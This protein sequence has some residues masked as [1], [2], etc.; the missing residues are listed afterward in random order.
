MSCLYIYTRTLYLF[1]ILELF[2]IMLH[3]HCLEIILWCKVKL[4]CGV[5]LFHLVEIS[6]K[7]KHFWLEKTTGFWM[8][9]S[10]KSIDFGDNNLVS[11]A[12]NL[13]SHRVQEANLDYY[14][15][16]PT[17]SKGCQLNPKGW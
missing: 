9:V 7:T 13:K 10:E 11:K 3:C 5:C 4:R 2:R 8:N 17:P 15:H 1:E 14:I 16:I 6:F 12:V